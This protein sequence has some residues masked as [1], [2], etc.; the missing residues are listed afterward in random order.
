MGAVHEK[1][2]TVELLRKIISRQIPRVIYTIFDHFSWIFFLMC[3]YIEH[4]HYIILYYCDLLLVFH[5]SLEQI[6]KLWT[7]K[8]YFHLIITFFQFLF[9][10]K[11]FFTHLI[12]LFSAFESICFLSVMTHENTDI[13]RVYICRTLT[14]LPVFR[15]CKV[16]HYNFGH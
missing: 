11:T 4:Q 1:N 13:F 7:F 15:Q 16:L 5:K 14:V 6:W 12:I 10:K 8:F 9:L 2:D 3:F